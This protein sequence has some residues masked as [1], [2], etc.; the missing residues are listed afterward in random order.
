MFLYEIFLVLKFLINDISK[1]QFIGARAFYTC[2]A[3]AC[4]LNNKEK[5]RHCYVNIFGNKE[6]F[7]PS[8]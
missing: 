4:S 5:Y 8:R 2:C 1:D 7:Y 6:E 3:F